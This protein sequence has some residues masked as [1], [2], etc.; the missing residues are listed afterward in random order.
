MI[1]ACKCKHLSSY[2][3]LTVTN[4]KKRIACKEQGLVNIGPLSKWYN[5][6]HALCNLCRCHYEVELITMYTTLFLNNLKS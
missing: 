5:E 4:Y 6:I 1:L 2:R 3:S